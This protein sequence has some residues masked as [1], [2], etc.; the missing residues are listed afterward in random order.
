MS[1]SCWF[2]EFK[3]IVQLIAAGK[4]VGEI[5]TECLENNLLGAVKEY[6]AKRMYA[7]LW[8]RANMLDDEL[9]Q[10]FMNS[11]LDTQKLINLIAVLRGDK[12]FF[13]FVYEVYREK[14]IIGQLDL[15][16]KDI[17]VFFSNKSNQSEIVENWNDSTKKHLKSN[18]ITCLADAGLIKI[19]KKI[20][21]ITKPIVDDRLIAY[22]EQCGE[23]AL[24]VAVMGVA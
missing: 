9:V 10:L 13:E 16:D 22:L 5:K 8:N 3:K 1:Q 7:Y 12:L 20:R 14:A 24:C 23:H 19:E 2:I 15:E 6:R 21:T 11:D 4:S 17:N 18:Y